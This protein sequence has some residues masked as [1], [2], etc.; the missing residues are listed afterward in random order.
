[1]SSRDT[2]LVPHGTRD[3]MATGS[4]VESIASTNR[5]SPSVESPN[6][7]SAI[8]KPR[9]VLPSRHRSALTMI[10][11]VSSAL[12]SRWRRM[13]TDSP[14]RR[15]RLTACRTAAICGPEIENER[16]YKMASSPSSSA[17]SPCSR[18]ASAP[19]ALAPMT[20]GA[21]P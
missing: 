17:L 20:A 12:S 2:P 9:S 18:Y 8:E 10:C 1:M 4:P 15:A 13:R 6:R 14:E 5:Q 21:Q 11:F 3:S 19:S 7:P 16:G